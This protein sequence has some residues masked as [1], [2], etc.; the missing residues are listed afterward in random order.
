[1]R[2]GA[3]TFDAN[4]PPAL[5]GFWAGLLR[6]DVVDVRGEVAVRLPGASDGPIMLFLPVPEGKVAK[7]RTHPDLHTD[8]LDAEVER[9]IA[10]GATEIDRQVQT[11][12]W[13]VLQDPEGNEFCIVHPGGGR[14][15]AASS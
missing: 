9:A 8:D 15:P 11:S 4:D 2:L 7:N 1:M 10:L 14:N 6:G 12:R 3:V 13:V 5:A